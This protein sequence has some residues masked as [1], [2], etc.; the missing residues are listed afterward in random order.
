V[1]NDTK[2]DKIHSYNKDYDSGK[3]KGGEK[4]ERGP[5]PIQGE[6]RKKSQKE[7]LRNSTPDKHSK[8]QKKRG[9][10]GATTGVKEK[11]ATC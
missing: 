10:R 1:R 7:S 11:A 6:Q 4:G 8:S 9:E 3:K 2:N 5:G